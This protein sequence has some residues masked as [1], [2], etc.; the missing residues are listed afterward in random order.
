MY[1]KILSK[2]SQNNDNENISNENNIQ[3]NIKKILQEIFTNKTLKKFKIEKDLTQQ[4]MRKLFLS[5]AKNAQF[6]K[7]TFNDLISNVFNENEKLSPGLWNLYLKG[8]CLNVIEEYEVQ[9][10]QVF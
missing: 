9:F 7:N 10:F 3:N 8:S 2:V 1:T 4:E 6:F 5:E